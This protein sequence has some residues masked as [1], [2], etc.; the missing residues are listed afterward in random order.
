MTNQLS[1]TDTKILSEVMAPLRRVADAVPQ[2][3]QPEA[4]E[5]LCEIKQAH[6]VRRYK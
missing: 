6:I 1:R 3:E 4:L 2:E 5:R